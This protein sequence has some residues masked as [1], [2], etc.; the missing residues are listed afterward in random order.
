MIEPGLVPLSYHRVCWVHCVG[1][2]DRLGRLCEGVTAE[3]LGFPGAR[4]FSERSQVVSS[5]TPIGRSLY[6]DC[7]ELPHLSRYGN[8]CWQPFYG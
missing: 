2:C 3:S 5:T 1:F 7:L 6:L 4:L 8:L